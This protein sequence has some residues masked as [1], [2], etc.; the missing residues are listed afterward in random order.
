[1]KNL[2]LIIAIAIFST[3]NA[4]T[5]Q[6]ASLDNNSN[7]LFMT[8]IGEK[9]SSGAFVVSATQEGIA[10]TKL[11]DKFG[12][13]NAQG[14]EILSARY[15]AIHPFQNGYAAIKLHGKW[16]FINKQGKK[17]T[18]FQY[19]WVG[20]FNEGAAAVQINGKWGF[21]NEQ[22]AQISEIEYDMVRSFENGIAM[23]RKGD[24]WLQLTIQGDLLPWDAAAAIVSKTQI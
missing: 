20:N 5:S 23:V 3:A 16:S 24:T 2:S 18:N 1:M 12:I 11:N 13:V 10:I 19:D 15:E 6:L 22:G 7:T 4:Q 8:G 14:V 17:I 9:T 21:I